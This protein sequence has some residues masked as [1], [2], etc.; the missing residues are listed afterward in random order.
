[1]PDPERTTPTFNTAVVRLFVPSGAPTIEAP[2]E[3][4]PPWSRRLGP[5]PSAGEPGCR[6]N[7]L[8]MICAWLQ[9]VKKVSDTCGTYFNNGSAMT[10]P[11]PYLVQAYGKLLL[12]K[13]TSVSAGS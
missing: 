11:P 7:H 8:R 1:M 9:V 5:V 6:L 2:I 3:T 10:L 13:V 12:L 4:P